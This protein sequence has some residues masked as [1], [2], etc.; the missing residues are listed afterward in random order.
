MHTNFDAFAAWAERHCA[1]LLRSG[2]GA[3]QREVTR[4]PVVPPDTVNAIV[5]MALLGK[6]SREISSQLG[7]TTQT[8]WRITNRRGIPLTP[9]R[10]PAPKKTPKGQIGNAA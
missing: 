8:A 3:L 5:R 1:R 10:P 6:T 4:G 7:V 9:C 2:G